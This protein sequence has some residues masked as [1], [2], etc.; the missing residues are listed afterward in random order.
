[1]R[2]SCGGTEISTPELGASDVN[3]FTTSLNLEST[4]IKTTPIPNAPLQ[5]S[6]HALPKRKA[7]QI[8][9][10]DNRTMN[11]P[12]LVPLSNINTLTVDSLPTHALPL[13]S[14]AAEEP[15]P[16]NYAFVNYNSATPSCSSTQTQSCQDAQYAFYTTARNLPRTQSP[17]D[18]RPPQKKSEFE[19]SERFKKSPLRQVQPSFRLRDSLSSLG[20]A[21]AEPA[22]CFCQAERS[23]WR[24]VG[25]AVGQK[26]FG[27]AVYRQ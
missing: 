16:S 10:R 7:N 20:G 11:Q 9:G 6:I 4:D 26:K 2:R 1:M 21:G 24:A 3:K 12:P 25:Q 13:T 14:S 15:L 19:D 18:T 8:G 23:E 17:I 22:V 27:Q 5:P